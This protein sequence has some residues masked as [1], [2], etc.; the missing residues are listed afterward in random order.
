MQD[1]QLYPIE[2]L[3]NSLDDN[4]TGDYDTEI[5]TVE[6]IQDLGVFEDIDEELADIDY[7][8]LTELE[9]EEIINEVEEIIDEQIETANT[10]QVEAFV[11]NNVEIINELNTATNTA[12]TTR[13]DTTT[14]F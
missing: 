10:E 12:A 6:E 3:D 7:E 13:P 8:E 9:Q 11:S 5:L 2:P 14:Y 1:Q 4:V